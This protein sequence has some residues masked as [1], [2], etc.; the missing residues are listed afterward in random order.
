MPSARGGRARN[1]AMDARIGFLSS[2]IAEYVPCM[3]S[4]WMKIFGY[5]GSTLDVRTHVQRRHGCIGR[6][7]A[8]KCKAM[9]QQYTGVL[10]L[11]LRITGFGHTPIPE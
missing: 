7:H 1:I 2:V 10:T 4:S 6:Q 11:S 8:Y 5:L 9:L 3:T